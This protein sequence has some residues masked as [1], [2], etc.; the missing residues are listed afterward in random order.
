[1]S[2][3]AERAPKETNVVEP[4]KFKWLFIETVELQSQGLA[5]VKAVEP[6]ADEKERRGMQDLGDVRS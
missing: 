3:A 4:G 1:M 2:A 5:I 6:A